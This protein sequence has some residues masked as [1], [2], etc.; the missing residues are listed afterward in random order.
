MQVGLLGPLTLHDD[1]GL[2]LPVPAAPKERAVLEMLALRPGVF[3]PIAELV[4]ALWGDKPPR[5]ASKALQVYISALRRFLPA[6]AIRTGSGGYQLQIDPDGVDVT[7]FERLVRAGRRAVDEMNM[8]DGAKGLQEALRLWR[9][10]PLVELAGQPAGIAER[11]RLTEIRLGAEESLVDARLALGEH[12]AM[13]GD[14]EAATATE[15]WRERRWAQ[16][17]LALYRSGRQADALAA[18]QRM[19]RHLAEG[20]GLE[21]SEQVAE[22]ERAILVHDSSLNAAATIAVDGGPGGRR[23]SLPAPISSFIGRDREASEV[24]RLLDE[25][26]LVTLTGVGGAGKTRLAVHVAS[27][28]AT[29]YRDGV[30]FVD[31]APIAAGDEVAGAVAGGLGVRHSSGSPLADVLAQFVA[32]QELLLVMDNC[33]HVIDEA[34]CITERLMAAGPGLK[35]LATSR[36]P[37]RTTG[38][39]IWPLSPL[40]FPAPDASTE[41]LSGSES[42]RL[43]VQRARD[44]DPDLTLDHNTISIIGEI[45]TLLDGLPL[46]VE[47]AASL[48]G[49]LG[50][51]E[52]RR[53]L[54][55]RF[56]LL[57]KGR[58][59]ALPRQQTLAATLDWSYRLL[60]ANEQRLLRRVSVFAGSFDVPAVEAVAVGPQ[61]DPD[62]VADDLWSLCTK[63][64]V[65]AVSTGHPVRRYRLLETT[66]QYA[67]QRLGQSGEQSAVEAAYLDYY[68]DL[69]CRAEADLRGPALAERLTSLRADHD[70]LLR[71]LRLLSDDPGGTT[72]GLRMLTA[73]HRYWLVRGDYAQWLALAEPLLTLKDA[74]VPPGLRARALAARCFLGSSFDSAGSY[75]WGE[76]AVETAQR[77]DDVSAE[78]EAW[79]GVA[80]N[81]LFAGR[82][83][84]VP[85]QKALALARQAGDPMLIGQAL[86]ASVFAHFNDIPIA[87][88]L[89]LEALEGLERSGDAIFEVFT[90]NNLGVIYDLSDDLDQ[91]RAC[92]DQALSVAAGLGFGFPVGLANIGEYLI[93]QG[94]IE[95]ATA[96]LSAALELARRY[97]LRDVLVTLGPIIGLAVALGDF[98]RAAQLRGYVATHWAGAGFEGSVSSD[99]FTEETVATMR[100]ELGASFE[101]YFSAGASLDSQAAIA[102]AQEV[103]RARSD[104]ET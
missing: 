94:E 44:V 4:D 59:T 70:N 34:A 26:R 98:Q 33:E 91:A 97:S 16:M 61:H 85:A 57:T 13:I 18:Y 17:M 5:S 12:E 82:T 80:V 56:A 9:G 30:W 6:L 88:R 77:A 53:R 37:L 64:L 66:R 8:D 15:P 72:A 27:Q 19:R 22:L 31:L 36:E 32:G 81:G 28:L 78:C 29:Q 48:A 104:T 42:V 68:V 20:L 7:M 23:G 21:P 54:D 95:A 63:S 84:P 76:Q 73:L 2:V 87:I 69:A 55:D 1:E 45:V 41:E 62:R 86:S 100:T 60:T 71:V 83:D 58:R 96:R 11:V 47:L 49:V 79:I 10:E 51:T 3:V 52:I 93:R 99:T 101:K 74:D 50:L 43:F 14:L 38:E 75:L 39:A 67:H 46:A 102:I 65:T 92:T 24:R 103:T 89:S 25:R 35:V 90:L 40:G